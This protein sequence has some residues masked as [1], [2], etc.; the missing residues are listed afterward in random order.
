MKISCL[1]TG[2]AMACGGCGGGTLEPIVKPGTAV[3]TTPPTDS[4]D[5]AAASTDGATTPVVAPSVFTPNA[6]CTGKG[7]VPGDVVIACGFSPSIA[8]LG[9]TA[10]HVVVITSPDSWGW[11]IYRINRATTKIDELAKGDGT[12][13]GTRN[14][15]GLRNF[16]F[17]AAAK[18]VL[19][20]DNVNGGG[21]FSI[22]LREIDIASGA[23]TLLR[24]Y[25]VSKALL[26]TAT[27]AYFSGDNQDSGFKRVARNGGAVEHVAS[28]YGE[29]VRMLNGLFYFTQTTATT[30]SLKRVPEGGGAV[31]DVVSD[32]PNKGDGVAVDDDGSVFFTTH[33]GSFGWKLVR[34]QGAARSDIF[35]CAEPELCPEPLAVFLHGADVF[36]QERGGLLRTPKT[37]VAA[38]GQGGPGSHRIYTGDNL[39]RPWFDGDRVILAQSHGGLDTPSEG[40]IVARK[41]TP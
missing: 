8:V 31:E 28:T 13:Y 11:K 23:K 3:S 4:P 18:T 39:G 27:H 20:H 10:E 30:T 29:P 5:A 9:A 24:D 16:A 32:V 35:E 40:T 38:A 41:L 7:A 2:L 37:G 25:G 21:G 14:F 33:N 26:S 17:S 19:H 36:V 12:V 22:G 1:M 34:V 15:F 6:N